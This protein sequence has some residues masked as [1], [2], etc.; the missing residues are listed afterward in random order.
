MLPIPVPTIPVPP[1]P[2]PIP[3]P[4]P[5]PMTSDEELKGLWPGLG[6]DMILLCNLQGLCDLF[7]NLSFVKVPARD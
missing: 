5:V 3:I 1:T 6:S 2:V 4:I 7:G